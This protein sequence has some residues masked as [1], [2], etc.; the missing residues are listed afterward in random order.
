M[1]KEEIDFEGALAELRNCLYS[2]RFLAVGWKRLAKKYKEDRERIEG[3]SN[4]AQH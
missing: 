2:S 4:E 3:G 1:G